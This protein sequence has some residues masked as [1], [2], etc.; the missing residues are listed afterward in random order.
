MWYAG[1]AMEAASA[2][3]VAEAAAVERAGT[4]GGPKCCRGREGREGRGGEGGGGSGVCGGRGGY[5]AAP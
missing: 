5:E 3:P 4:G 2:A 1:G